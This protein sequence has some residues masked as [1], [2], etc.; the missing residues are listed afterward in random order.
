M[1]RREMEFRD[2]I[3][4]DPVPTYV[5]FCLEKVTVNVGLKSTLIQRD[6]GGDE[7]LLIS[8]IR[9]IVSLVSVIRLFL[10]RRTSRN[11]DGL[12]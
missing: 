7:A 6:R 10:P 9:S 4:G 5:L 1:I 3:L 2:R 12:Q 8:I 11:P